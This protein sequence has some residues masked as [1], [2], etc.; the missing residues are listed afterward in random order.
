MGKLLKSCRLPKLFLLCETYTNAT[1]FA[2]VLL[3]TTLLRISSV[4]SKLLVK[5]G[6]K[7]RIIG[8]RI[9]P[10]FAALNMEICGCFV[11]LETV[12]WFK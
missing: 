4:I 3:H 5:L 8:Y 12:H 9:L 11:H 6:V 1:G 10:K 7:Y 2:A